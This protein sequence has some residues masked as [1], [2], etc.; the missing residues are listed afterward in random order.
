MK[1][2]LCKTSIIFC[3]LILSLQ[4]M[5]WLGLEPLTRAP[6]NSLASQA[7]VL[8]ILWGHL[9]GDFSRF[10]G[11][12]SISCRLVERKAICLLGINGSCGGEETACFLYKIK[13]HWVEAGIPIFDSDAS[14]LRSLTTLKI[15]F[16]KKRRSKKLK[17]EDKNSFIQKLI[18]TT[19]CLLPE[20]W[21][22]RIKAELF[23]TA[24]FNRERINIVQD[25][26]GV[27]AT[28]Y[29]KLVSNY[30]ILINV[31]F[32]KECNNSARI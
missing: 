6:I 25:Y 16:D 22:R 31:I 4:N 32:F 23:H 11:M 7:E 8:Q 26:I 30:I 20:D 29:F 17:P 13:Q 27:A 19:F 10:R 1:Q 2:I 12:A 14:C 5:E 28:R 18:S 9:D 21:E 15:N 24:A 3:I